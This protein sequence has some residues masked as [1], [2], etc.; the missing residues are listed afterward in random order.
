MTLSSRVELECEP[1]ASFFPFFVLG[2][3]ELGGADVLA[4]ASVTRSMTGVKRVLVSRGRDYE[5][6]EFRAGTLEVELDDAAAEY[7]PLN[8]ESSFYGSVEPG[9]T[10]RV[11]ATCAGVDYTLFTGRTQKWPRSNQGRIPTAH[12]IAGDA[13]SIL[14]KQTLDE[15]AASYSGDTSGARISRV[16]DLPEVSFGGARSIDAGD[17]T[18]GAT[19]F[20]EEGGKALAYVQRAAQSEQGQ[21]FVTTDGTLRFIRRNNNPGSSVATFS[22]DGAAGSIRYEDL[23]QDLDDT[24]LYNRVRT[25]GTAGTEFVAE[26]S[27]SQGAYEIRALDRTGQF[28]LSDPEVQTQGNW[29]LDRLKAPSYP[30]RRLTVDLSTLADA[31]RAEVFGL[32]IGDLVTVEHTPLGMSSQ[33]VQLSFV[34]GLDFEF[35]GET[36]QTTAAVTVSRAAE[37]L[38]FILGHS[39]FG[40]LGVSKLGH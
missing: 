22:D 4:P 20:T 18:F 35:D 8:T 16:L 40:V 32:E 13:L 1:R 17:S 26:D 7:H 2:V 11:V 3:S 30:L 21:L 33:I 19:T 36:G 38:F 15:V 27:T 29:L 37:R 34:D 25:S 24:L 14:A 31:R 10:I 28:L 39:D 23:Q 12:C 9:K 5:I 6:D